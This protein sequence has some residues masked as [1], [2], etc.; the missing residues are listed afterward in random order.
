MEANENKET[1]KKSLGQVI[2]EHPK[3]V[4]WTR[5]VSWATFACVL[6]FIFIVWR[7]KLFGKISSIQVGGWGIFAI[8]I[9]AIF[10]FSIIRYI[11]LAFKG[12][13][14]LTGQ[15]LSGACKIIL[16]LVVFMV[17]LWGLR[18][19][20]DLM[21]Q[22]LGCVIACE[23]I[24]IPLNPLPKWAYDMQKETRDNEKKD[25]VDYLLTEFFK[26]KKDD[27]E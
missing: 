26:K 18:N 16:P 5:F 7:F 21:L 2:D 14:S 15:I 4:F 8:L 22:A 19:S 13:Y 10:V 12:R 9:V 27:N 24:A 3:T 25:T 17:I 20:I 6:P 23:A 11:K 1:K